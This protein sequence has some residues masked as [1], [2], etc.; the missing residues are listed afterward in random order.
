MRTSSPELRT[1]GSQLR[2]AGGLQ[3]KT[4]TS[5]IYVACELTVLVSQV[6]V[7]REVVVLRAGAA[8]PARV[9]ARNS[10]GVEEGVGSAHAAPVWIA[11][12]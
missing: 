10:G 6:E 1:Q 8:K 7:I 2:L 4:M 3:V 5:S 12:A 9:A 11:Q